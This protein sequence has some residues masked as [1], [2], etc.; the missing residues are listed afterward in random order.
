MPVISRPVNLRSH[1]SRCGHTCATSGMAAGP[2]PLPPP[3]STSFRFPGSIFYYM[4]K[5]RTSEHRLYDFLPCVPKQRRSQ[6][7]LLSLFYVFT[8]TRK[9]IRSYQNNRG[10]VCVSYSQPRACPHTP[11]LI[12]GGV[13]PFLRPHPSSSAPGAEAPGQHGPAD[14]AL[15]SPEMMESFRAS[16]S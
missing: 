16:S 4:S 10:S 9:S 6:S 11:L 13:S 3:P 8:K 15:P 5:H 14:P 7:Y 12:L 1:T 2:H